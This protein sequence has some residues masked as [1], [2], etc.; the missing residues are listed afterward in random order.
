M[1]R[2]SW[3]NYALGSVFDVAVDL[4]RSSPTFGGWFVDYSATN[5]RQL[6]IPSGLAHGFAITSDWA[7]VHYKTTAHYSPAFERGLRW[8]DPDVGIDWPLDGS[9]LLVQRTAGA[10][11]LQEAEVFE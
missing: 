10:P 2:E 3:C 9:P 8:D 5:H 1:P 6:W 4:R 11:L 7:E